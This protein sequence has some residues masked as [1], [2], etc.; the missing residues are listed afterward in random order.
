MF[1]GAV[2]TS[3]L[4]AAAA[5]AQDA[6]TN[7]DEVVVTGTRIKRADISGVGPATVITEEQIANT[8]ITN[9]ENLL[10]RLPASA[11]NA[12]GQTN[13]YWTGNGYGTAQSQSAAA[14]ASIGL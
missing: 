1:A 6:T 14:L 12:G 11:G 5:S 13:A 3:T 10:Q 8:G 7:I 4:C 9:L 2:I